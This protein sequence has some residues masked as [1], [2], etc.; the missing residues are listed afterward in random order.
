M[1]PFRSDPTSMSEA[2]R[3]QIS[4]APN[5]SRIFGHVLLAR[6]RSRIPEVPRPRGASFQSSHH[7]GASLPRPYS[8]TS[9]PGDANRRFRSMTRDA[10][11][12]LLPSHTMRPASTVLNPS[13][14]EAR[15]NAPDCELPSEIPQRTMPATGLGVPD[16]SA[17]S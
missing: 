4:A 5:V 8:S 6:Q 2:R 9:V 1:S 11:L 14:L 3:F 17:F 16:A 12:G 10:M 7:S 15:R 13:L